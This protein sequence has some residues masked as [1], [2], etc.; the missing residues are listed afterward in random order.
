MS[1]ESFKEDLDNKIIIMT[2]S[3]DNVAVAKQ[4]INCRELIRLTTDEFKVLSFVKKAQRLAIRDIKKGEFLKQYGYSFGM[5][6]GISKGEIISVNNTLNIVPEISMGKY[7][8]P[9][10]T[11][12]DELYTKKIFKGYFRE[13]GMVGTRNYYLV[14][15]TSMCANDTAIQIARI[16]EDEKQS[17]RKSSAFDGVLAIPHTEGCGCDSGVQ[18]DRLLLILKGYVVH[19]NVG[20]CLLLDLGC[21]Q[22]NYE[23]VAAYMGDLTS[24]NIKPIDWITIENIGGVEAAREKARGIISSRLPAVMDIKRKPC[25]LG[26]LIVGTECGAS[27]SFSGI[28]AN[29]L[30]GN[31]VDKVIHGKGSAILSEMPEMVGTLEMLLP[32][33]RSLEIAEKFISA[34]DWY[35]NFA[36]K[37]GLTLEANLVPK[38]IEGGLINNYIKSLGAVLKGGTTAIEDVVDYGERVKRRGLTIMQGPGGDPE[39]V[40]GIVASGANI[41]CFSTGQ[42]TPGGSVICPVV[43][44]ATNNEVFNK[45]SRDIDFNAGRMLTEPASFE[46]LAEELLELVIKV[47]SGQETAAERLGQR[48]FQIW[49]AGKLSL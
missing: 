20:G 38:N 22:T 41:I 39:S 23:R 8:E 19:P 16:F 28:T 49:T 11:K 21:E 30:I 29:P 43:K 45:L 48:Q 26:E 7:K 31:V 4:D 2:P 5:S 12:Y 24:Q 32:R 25:P 13:N 40:T 37:L 15:P 6:K 9:P 35:V 3:S 1:N 46:A 47:A 18:I 36:K 14:I 34:M 10:E 44:V 42:G 27:D 17:L 33:F